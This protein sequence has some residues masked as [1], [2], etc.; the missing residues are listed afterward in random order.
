MLFSLFVFFTVFASVVIFIAP[1]LI[2][3]PAIIIGLTVLSFPFIIG[4]AGIAW[5]VF[6]IWKSNSY[7]ARRQKVYIAEQSKQ[8]QRVAATDLR[9]LM[10]DG[11]QQD[12]QDAM[13]TIEAR[14]I[15][16]IEA[17][18]NEAP[19]IVD[20]SSINTLQISPPNSSSTIAC[21]VIFENDEDTERPL[22]K[23]IMAF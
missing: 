13:R 21:E 12:L 23:N 9:G 20:V 22:S 1:A 4:L 17:S 11:Q 3:V 19:R 6:L 15:E 16:D 2:F 14:R 7:L 8:W 18:E 10:D 5:I